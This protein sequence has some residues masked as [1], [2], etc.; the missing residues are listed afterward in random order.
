MDGYLT[1]ENAEDLSYSDLDTF[2]DFLVQRADEILSLQ[3]DHNLI[4]S[5]PRSISTF[6]NLI[7][8]DLSNNNL[9]YIS[10]CIVQLSSLRTLYLRNNE[11]DNES[12]PKDFGILES[13][14]V[15]NFSGNR[16]TDFPV[17]VTELPQLHVLHLGANKIKSIPKEIGSLQSLEVLYMGGNRLTEVPDEVGHLLN[18]KSLVLCD[19]RINSL[20]GTIP[21]LQNLRSLSLHNNHI[22]TLP[23]KLIDLDLIELSLRN[24]PLVLRFVQDMVYEAPSLKEL[25]GR[26]IKIKNIQYTPEDLPATLIHYLDSGSSC[27]N[28]KCK[29]VFFASKVEHVKFVDFCGKYRLPLLQ[30]LCSPRCTTAPLVACSSDS[31][32]DDDL[33][34]VE[35]K[36]RRVLLG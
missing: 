21:N 35:N 28:P 16:F 25:S 12:L 1:E 9:R 4:S 13:L 17:Q 30:Y 3:L 11:L 6:V 2:P 22:S 36:M 15:V 7:N 10:P 32:S 18:L 31:E 8:L 14:K 26:V 34:I 23:P 20:P 29:G 5:L 24:N 27:V 19:N 33:P